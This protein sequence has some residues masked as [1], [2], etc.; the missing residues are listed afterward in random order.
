M[1][2]RARNGGG[3]RSD[4]N[5]TEGDAVDFNI[6]VPPGDKNVKVGREGGFD[7]LAKFLNMVLLLALLRGFVGPNIKVGGG[8]IIERGEAEVLRGARATRG[9]RGEGLEK[10]GGA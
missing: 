2:G 3:R 5:A 6:T 1:L 9:R 7:D 4:F 10:L 8:T